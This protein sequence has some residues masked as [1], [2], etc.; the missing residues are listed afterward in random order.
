MARLLKRETTAGNLAL[1]DPFGAANAFMSM[2]VTG[3]VRYILAA[4]PLP[5]DELEKRVAFGVRLF[6]DGARPR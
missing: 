2:V 6:L 1:D 5:P 4:S 3:P